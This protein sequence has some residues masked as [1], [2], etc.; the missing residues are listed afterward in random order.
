MLKVAICDDEMRIVEQIESFVLRFGRENNMDFKTYK[1]YDGETLVRSEV[2]F[3]L[4]FLDIMMKRLDGIETGKFIKE[5]NMETQIVYIS[6]FSDYSMRAHKVHAFDFVTKPIVY[7]KINDV[8]K[9]LKKLNSN[10]HITEDFIRLRLEDYSETLVNTDDILYF[11]YG[12]SRKVYVYITDG[13]ILKANDTMREILER[14]N[15]AQFAQPHKSYIVNIKYVRK[16]EKG[17]KSIFMV[18]NKEIGLSQRQQKE[19]R[20]KLHSYMRV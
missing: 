6:S 11:E 1:F 2:W 7:S 17:A 18:N 13:E 14:V 5:R 19:F 9:D 4:V 8:L 10:K 20:E 16:I 3:D 15:P 12:E